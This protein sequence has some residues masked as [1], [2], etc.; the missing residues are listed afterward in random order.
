MYPRVFLRKGRA[1]GPLGLNLIVLRDW[2]AEWE[3]TLTDGAVVDLYD[4]DRFIAR[5]LFNSKSHWT[6]RLLTWEEH[7][8]IDDLFFEVRLR[9][10]LE[11]R[12]LLIQSKKSNSFRWVFG[13]GDRLPGLVVD[14]FDQVAVVQIT[15]LGIYQRCESIFS[16]LRKLFPLKAIILKEEALSR[17]EGIDVEGSKLVWGELPTSLM[18][19]EDDLK[20]H[21]D[22]WSGQKTGFYLDQRENRAL[23]KAWA[24]KQR[25]LDLCCFS[26][27]FALAAAMGGARE[28]IGVDSS[29]AAIELAKRNLLLNGLSSHAGIHF[30]VDDLLEWLAEHSAERFDL[31]NL[32][33]PKLVPSS[34][35]KEAGLRAYYRM[36]LEA[37]R[38][39]QPGGIFVTH[40]CSGHV[41]ADEFRSLVTAVCRKLGRQ[42]RLIEMRGH[43]K[44]HPVLISSP[45]SEYL[46]TLY[47]RVF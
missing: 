22:V 38:L 21:V 26:G 10:A 25:V 44:D 6:V 5:G 20:F 16:S 45:S 30:F 47:L 15:C 8:H 12:A 37:L 39:L 4:R 19:E 29:D 17:K 23:V 14:V 31:I 36:N 34:K 18:V 13:E 41:Q 1:G 28:V 35:A 2:V 27:G 42:A 9:E 33:P 40:S 24:S 32:D 46:K 7:Q 3:P 11:H 43:A